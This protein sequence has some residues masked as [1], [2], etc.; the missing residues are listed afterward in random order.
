MPNLAILS[1]T[2]YRNLRAATPP[3]RAF[4][5]PKASGEYRFMA[6]LVSNMLSI[7]NNSCF[8]FLSNS[9]ARF[10]SLRSMVNSFSLLFASRTASLRSTSADCRA[11]FT[12]NNAS[13]TAG[14]SVAATRC[15]RSSLRISLSNCRTT[16]IAPYAF[17]PSIAC[18]YA[19][20][21]FWLS[22]SCSAAAALKGRATATAVVSSC[23]PPEPATAASSALSA[24][25]A[26]GSFHSDQLDSVSESATAASSS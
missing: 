3:L 18:L 6:C 1:S 19:A 13:A 10:V 24:P 15:L 14:C 12:S 26:A 23:L 4:P 22:P 11:C 2:S 20:T 7:D 21:R 25:A 9:F 5:W 8:R 16:V 17:R